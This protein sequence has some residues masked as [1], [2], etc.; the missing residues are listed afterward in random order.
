MPAISGNF[1]R[2]RCS[3]ALRRGGPAGILYA[4]S[5]AGCGIDEEVHNAALKD[6]DAQKAKLA[7]CS[8]CTKRLLAHREQFRN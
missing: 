8:L 2:M 6:R 3:A 4:I 1:R 5:T 7:V